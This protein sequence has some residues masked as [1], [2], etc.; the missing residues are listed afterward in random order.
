LIDFP[1]PCSDAA[2][3]IALVGRPNVGKSTLL[4]RLAG[5]RRAIAHSL[6]G[7]T[8]DERDWPCTLGDARLVAWD[9]PG[10]LAV[11]AERGRARQRRVLKRANHGQT[12]SAYGREARPGMGV[13]ETPAMRDARLG[14]DIDEAGGGKDAAPVS[15]LAF[16]DVE[17]SLTS[18]GG[19]VAL[20]HDADR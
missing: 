13:H 2:L 20:K 18:G 12:Q 9:T 10:V 5:R 14:L 7:L 6:P 15:A 11:E 8:R 3:S 1:R 19:R 17:P 16:V 4:N